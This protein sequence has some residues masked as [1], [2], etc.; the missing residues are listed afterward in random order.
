MSARVRADCHR[1]RAVF[2]QKLP[3]AMAYALL[4]MSHDVHPIPPKIPLKSV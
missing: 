3:M 4:P 1:L 2:A